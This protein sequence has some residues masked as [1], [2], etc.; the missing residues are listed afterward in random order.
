VAG[1]GANEGPAAGAEMNAAAGDDIGG[2]NPGG[3]G[4]DMEG[5]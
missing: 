1:P 2:R 3:N 4:M 5:K